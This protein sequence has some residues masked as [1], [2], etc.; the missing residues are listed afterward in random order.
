MGLLGHALEW[1]HTDLIEQLLLQVDGIFLEVVIIFTIIV[2]S[3]GLLIITE[4]QL[5]QGDDADLLLLLLEPGMQQC[6]RLNELSLGLSFLPR[7]LLGA[8]QTFLAE[9]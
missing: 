2:L 5:I 3:F 6:Q 1:Q 4:L 8:L 9:G 7:P